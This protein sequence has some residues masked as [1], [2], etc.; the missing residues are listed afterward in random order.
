[1]SRF[2]AKLMA[3]SWYLVAYPARLW[4]WRAYCAQWLVQP[5]T[6]WCLTQPKLLFLYA[7]LKLRGPPRSG[8]WWWWLLGWGAT[9]R[10]WPRGFP[11]WVT[12][13]P[14]KIGPKVVTQLRLG[15]SVDGQLAT[16]KV[17]RRIMR[18]FPGGTHTKHKT[19]NCTES[20]HPKTNK[21]LAPSLPEKGWLLET[22][23]LLGWR[24]IFSGFVWALLGFWEVTLCL[25]TRRWGR[26]IY[27]E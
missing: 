15:E 9:Q 3:S 20:T 10:E 8:H 16:N 19:Q 21:R 17:Q 12:E 27:E 14:K 2:Q 18:S 5:P 24:R 1:M 6:R 4:I 22:T 11:S 25:F 26:L 13:W 7:T 23:F